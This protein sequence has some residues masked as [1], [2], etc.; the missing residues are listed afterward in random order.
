G[1]AF[2]VVLCKAPSLVCTY[3][4]L[5][6]DMICILGRQ[7]EF[8]FFSLMNGAMWGMLA[9]FFSDIRVVAL[10]PMYISL[11]ATILMDANY[12]TFVSS[13]RGF[14]LLIPTLVVM[15]TLVY[16]RVTEFKPENMSSFWV[17]QHTLEI[18]LIDVFFNTLVTMIIFMLRVA[19]NKRK[20]LRIRNAGCKMVRCVI[21]RSNLVLK[22]IHYNVH[23]RKN[24]HATRVMMKALGITAPNLFLQ[25][26]K[27]TNHRQQVTLVSL[28]LSSIDERRTINPCY[29]PK[30]PI[31]RRWLSFLYINGALGFLLSAVTIGLPSGKELPAVGWHQLQAIPM[32]GVLLS[33]VFCLSFACSF[34]RDLLRC[35]SKNFGFLFSSLQFTMACLCLAD[36]VH[37]DYRSMAILAAFMWYHWILLLDTLTPTIRQKFRFK[38]IYATP[39]LVGVLAGVACVV[40]AL[41]FSE[42]PWDDRILFHWEFKDHTIELGTKSFLLNRA[43]T[44]WVWSA[45]LVW[46][47]G[48]SADEELVFIRGSLDYYTPFETFQ[49]QKRYQNAS[50]VPLRD[51]EFTPSSEASRRSQSFTRARSSPML[52]D[53][54]TILLTRKPSIVVPIDIRFSTI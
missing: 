32:S 24:A 19:Y 26:T 54:A 36:M 39:V 53:I 29:T 5:S 4:L 34:Q 10:L 35:L 23:T 38:K 43:I 8:W 1:I 22:R 28:K 42:H 11:Q 2:T 18:Q 44:I 31:P 16:T 50:I 51:S 46:E 37:W 6:I 30:R 20:L 13:V 48:A 9:T 47:L 25:Q 40:Y 17:G 41:T 7:Y 3:V 27:H 14:T 49:T 21:Y 45:R 33:S 52:F 12:R 15:G